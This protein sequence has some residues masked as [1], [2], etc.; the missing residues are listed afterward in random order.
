MRALWSDRQNCSQNVS[1]ELKHIK[2]IAILFQSSGS[3]VD[4]T[5]LTF[6]S[7]RPESDGKS[8]DT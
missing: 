5:L 6:V 7:S 3:G 1:Q 4:L 2:R 8:A